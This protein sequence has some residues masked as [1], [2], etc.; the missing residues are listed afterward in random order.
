MH[1]YDRAAYLLWNAIGGALN[2]RGWPD[3]KI[4]AYLQSKLVRVALDNELGD[5]I[6]R[7]GKR[8]AKTIADDD[9]S[10]SWIRG[11]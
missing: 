8:F 4:K 2:K 9:V 10:D 11:E 1:S 5:M 6:E 7:L 3:A